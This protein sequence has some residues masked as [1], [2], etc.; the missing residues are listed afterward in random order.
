[1]PDDAPPFATKSEWVYGRLRDL[2]TEGEFPPGEHL[3]LLDLARRFRVSEMPVREA[4]RM[5][6]RDGLV[7]MRSHRGAVVTDVRLEQVY[8]LVLA[9]MHLEEV[10]LREAV[11]RHDEASLGPARRA[12]ERM[13]RA[14][15]RGDPRSFSVGNRRFHAALYEPCPHA[16]LKALVQE[17]WDR[18]WH[19]RT[20]SLFRVRRERM[21]GALE[22]HRSIL[23]AVAS[24]DV[25]GAV[26]RFRGHRDR[27]LAAWRA[28][29][30]DAA[31]ARV[32]PPG[33]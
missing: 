12:L 24:G 14:A 25:G 28:V 8:E 13:E 29:L 17:L 26:A 18:L 30:D 32:V 21:G 1:M 15:A 2:I 16:L 31:A 9:R 19:T 11:P 5:L 33:G 23:D 22:E 7:E 10:A 6:Q 3:R 27:T 4:L 20:Q